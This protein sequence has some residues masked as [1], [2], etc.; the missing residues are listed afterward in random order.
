MSS[1]ADNVDTVFWSCEFDTVWFDG[2]A[3]IFR[4]TI[5]LSSAE[6]GKECVPPIFWY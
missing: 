4:R 3:R 5:T 2:Q 1:T 6:S